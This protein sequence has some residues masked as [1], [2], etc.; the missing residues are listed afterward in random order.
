LDFINHVA[1]RNDHVKRIGKIKIQID[2]VGVEDTMIC[3]AYAVVEPK[4]MVITS[5]DAV[6][7][8]GAVGC[9]LEFVELAV[10]AIA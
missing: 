1:I 4:A 2:Q 9:K 5:L 3:L 10:I 7:T 6:C 8:D